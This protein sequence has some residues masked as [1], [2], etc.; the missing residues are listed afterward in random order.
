LGSAASIARATKISAATVVRFFAKLGYESFAEA[1]EEIRREVARKLNSPMDR[2]A[3]VDTNA[4][5]TEAFLARF[6]ALEVD[7]IKSTFQQ[8]DT[9]NFEALIACILATKGKIYII[10]EK[11]SHPIAYLIWAHLNICLDNVVLVDTGEAMVADRLLWAGTGDILIC[12]SVRRYS[13]NGLR[14]AQHFRSIG[15]DVA[16]LT[17]NA[18]S[19]LMPY[20]TFRL[21]V[22]TANV[23]VFDSYT[24]MISVAGA[25]AG[26]VARLRRNELYATLKRGE[27]LWSRF[28]TFLG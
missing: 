3:I 24:A 12:V 15:A 28:G 11:N 23:S 25:I 20:A 2:M 13:P 6:H 22:Q 26:V 19:P 9:S 10:G 14:A 5:S 1:Q 21:L 18:L 16:V 4:T 17:D 7:N 8:I 27:E